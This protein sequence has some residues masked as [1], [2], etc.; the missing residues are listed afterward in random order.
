MNMAINQCVC[1]GLIGVGERKRHCLIR[2]L[3][4]RENNVSVAGGWAVAIDR[5]SFVQPMEKSLFSFVD[6]EDVTSTIR[7][8]CLSRKTR[9]VL[10]SR[11]LAMNNKFSRH[12]SV[13]KERRAS[14]FVEVSVMGAILVKEKCFCLIDEEAAVKANA[15]FILR[16]QHELFPFSCRLCAS[17]ETKKSAFALF[18]WN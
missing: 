5:D 11:K 3:S 15:K 12:L 2:Q 17:D 18:K 13:G 9:D 1:N 4:N 16:E 6:S 7:L 8:T 14:L 10:L